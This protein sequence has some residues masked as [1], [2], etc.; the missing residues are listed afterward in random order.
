MYPS[1]PGSFR[2]PHAGIT[3]LVFVFLFCGG[4]AALSMHG[5]PF[6]PGP[7]AP[8][9]D[10]SNFFAVRA[11]A[12]L[13]CA[14]L[15][16][17]SAIPFGI[18][19]ATI[20]SQLEFLGVRAA[21]TKLALFGGFSSALAALLA[22]SL[23]WAMAVPTVSQDSAV[24]EA[25]YRFSFAAGGLGFCMLFGIFIAGVAVSAGLTR[26]IPRW[27]MFAGVAIAFC[28]ELSWF[29]MLSAKFLPFIP[30]SR[31]AGYLWSI[32]IGFYLPRT[33]QLRAGS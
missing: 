14:F 33:K 26:V 5:A 29:Q 17:G 21:G 18:F 16:L 9:A 6:F 23:L 24:L 3:A 25:F 1:Q 32:V 20:V 11:D 15:Q 13:L 7:A 31:F 27:L 4:V 2:G 22:S 28:G 19:V 30:L 8:V 10:I 12:A